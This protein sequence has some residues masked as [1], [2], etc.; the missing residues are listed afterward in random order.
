MAEMNMVPLIDVMLVLLV[1]FIVTAPLLSHSVRIELPQA[2]SKSVETAPAK[3]DLAI[4][5]GG[6][7]LYNGNAVDRNTAQALFTEAARKNPMPEVHIYAD[8]HADYQYVAQTLADASR[9][10]LT[11]IGFITRPQEKQTISP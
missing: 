6:E 7:L 5:S 2:S 4:Q 8:R 3:I 1:I 10:G 9:A 11:T